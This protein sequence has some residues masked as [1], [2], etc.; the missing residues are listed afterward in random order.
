MS[1]ILLLLE[2]QENQRLLAEALAPRHQVSTAS[3]LPSACPPVDLIIVDGLSLDRHEETLHQWKNNQPDACLPVL[4]VTARHDVGLATRALWKYVDELILTPVEKVELQARVE[5]LLNQRRLSLDLSRSVL[6]HAPLAFMALDKAHKVCLW[7]LAAERLFGWSAAEVLGHP[8]P[9][10]PTSEQEIFSELLRRVMCGETFQEFELRFQKRNGERVEGIASA[11][12]RRNPDQEV[13]HAVLSFLELTALRKAE[14]ENK[15]MAVELLQAQKMEAVGRLAAGVAHDFNNM[16]SVIITTSEMALESLP[17]EDPLRAD[18]MEIHNAGRRSAELTS[19]LLAF[20]RKQVIQPKAVDLNAA[21][22]NAL[23][24]LRRLVGEDIEIC[25][26]PAPALWPIFIDPSQLDQILMNLAVNARDAIKNVGRITLAT[27]NFLA[28]LA[29][30]QMHPDAQPGEY[31]QLSFADNG[32]GMTPEIKQR[33]FEPF[34]TTKAPDKGT[35]MGLATVFGIVK[36]HHGIISVYSEPGLGTVF[37]IYFPRYRHEDAAETAAAQPVIGGGN[38]TILLVEDEL[39]L[40]KLTRTILERLGYKVLSASRPQEALRL[41]AE[42]PGDIHL[43]ISDVVL[44]EA[45]ALDMVQQIQQH[46]PGIRCLFMSGYTA[47]IMLQRG[48]HEPNATFLQKPFTAQILAAKVREAL[49]KK[50]S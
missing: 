12:P 34:F 10:V 11:S 32:C 7:N 33:I 9:M 41:S 24:M 2:N 19:R 17:A 49:S 26:E 44:P 23:K 14:A 5:S 31:V 37:R 3:V 36:Q 29:F 38:E 30:C 4:M 35:G 43:V 6:R 47:D 16:L 39:S 20:A 25:W 45:T 13:A 42:H 1:A 15:K 21:I 28:D 50:P 8:P 40:L 22:Q 46:R 18:L 27:E 48:L